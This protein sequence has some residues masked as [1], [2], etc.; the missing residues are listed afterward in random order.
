SELGSQL[1]I[2][3]TELAEQP[4]MEKLSMAA[5]IFCAVV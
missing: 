4:S 2:K 3:S 1:L 5:T